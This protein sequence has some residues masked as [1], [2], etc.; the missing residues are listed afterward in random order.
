MC[1]LRMKRIVVI[2]PLIGLVVLCGCAH[3]YLMKLSNGDQILSL[4][5]P[6]RQGTL[7]KFTDESGESHLIPRDRVAKIRAVS[8]VNEEQKPSRPPGP[9]KAKHWYF[10]WLA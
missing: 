10:L 9:K 1:L 8:I 3:Q 5:K 2:A 7:Y 4:S 6:K